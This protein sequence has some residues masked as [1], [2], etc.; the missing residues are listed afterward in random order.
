[1]KLFGYIVGTMLYM[2]CVYHL[3]CF[4]FTACNPI[5]T[6]ML[7]VTLSALETLII[8]SVPKKWK[9]KVFWTISVLYLLLYSVQMV[10]FHIF[11]QPLLWEAAIL[12]GGD[13]LTNYWREALTGIKNM[14]PMILLLILPLIGAAFLFY[15]RKWEL[16]GLRKAEKRAEWLVLGIGLLLAIGTLKIGKDTNANFYED[17]KE[18]YDPLTV[19]ENMGMLAMAQ[20]DTSIHLKKL[21]QEVWEGFTGNSK[22]AAEKNEK[23]LLTAKSQENQDGQENELAKDEEKDIL[24]EKI[25]KNNAAALSENQTEEKQKRALQK[26]NSDKMP[27]KEK[28]EYPEYHKLSIDFSYLEEK[29]DSEETEWLLEYLQTQLPSKTN[30]YTGLF[31]GY[32]LI[33][34]T[35][36][37]FSPYA[38]RQ[39]LTP[40]LYR[41]AHSGIICNN[42]YVPLWQTSTSDGEYINCTGLIP[43]GQFSMRKSADNDMA[44]TLPRYFE[45]EGVKSFAYHNN[46]LTYYD[47]DRTH[48]NLGYDFKAARLGDLS[49]E[50]AGDKIFPMENPD[51]WPT[52]D[53]EMMQGTVG[54]YINLDRFHVY[55]MTVSGHMNYN[56]DGNSM[57]FKNKEAVK[58]LEMSENAKAY[59]ACHI[60]LDKALEYLLEQLE[61]AG[62]LESTVICLSAD[63]YPYGMTEEEYE[64]LAGK[65]LSENLDTYRN[66]LILWNKGLEDNVVEVEKVCGS[67][68]ILPTLLNLFGFSYDSRLYA[69]RDIFSEEEGLVILNDRSFLTDTVI[70]NRKNGKIVWKEKEASSYAQS[71]TTEEEK[72]QYLEEKKQEVKQRYQFSAYVLQKDY[73]RYI[74]EAL[75]QK[76]QDLES[77]ESLE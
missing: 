7:I 8:G 2:E 56:F 30:E 32:N 3:G 27:Q 48:P 17:Y 76:K 65:S 45:K 15:G 36:E 60:E 6:I 31:Q 72:E 16:P 4:G 49:E 52:S 9:R 63:H 26:S 25:V 44:F 54:E 58:D 61:K 35:A 67:M 71:F 5:F 37:G 21:Q 24:E 47:R 28:S 10:Y 53:L 14:I 13:A 73:Y 57:S 19:A 77:L 50:E 55:Y 51:L 18:F 20:R 41:L 40:T 74:R 70:Y 11:R 43:D 66:Q 69:G 23:V 75:G 59:L 42:Y 12:G 1:M 62:K 29:A 22:Q 38:I 39:D 68:D 64:E 46:S 33:Y 34:I